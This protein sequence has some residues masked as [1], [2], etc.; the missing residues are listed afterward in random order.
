MESPAISNTRFVILAPKSY[1]AS[2]KAKMAAN[3]NT[4]KPNVVGR[5]TELVEAP[6]RQP[7]TAMPER[8]NEESVHQALGRLFPSV[9]STSTHM[10]SSLT[11]HARPTFTPKNAQPGTGR[12]SYNP[13]KKQINLKGSY[14][15]VCF[16]WREQIM[17]RYDYVCNAN[18]KERLIF[19]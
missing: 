5:L 4:P 17:A 14:I 7:S 3:H 19:C 15:Y 1:R 11:A 12:S 16:F 10:P 18:M 9:S 13:G 2:C 8:S 6:R